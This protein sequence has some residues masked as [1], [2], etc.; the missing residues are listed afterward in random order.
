[1]VEVVVVIVVVNKWVKE[2]MRT[3]VACRGMHIENQESTME[4]WEGEW[5][6]GRATGR[7]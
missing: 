3:Y 4:Q 6:S 2:R 7:R 5:E 1:V